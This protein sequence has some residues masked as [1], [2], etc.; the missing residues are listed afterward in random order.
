MAKIDPSGTAKR[1]FRSFRNG[2]S[3]HRERGIDPLGTML[4][5][6]GNG[7]SIYQEL[8]IAGE[9]RNSGDSRE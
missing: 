8:R 3:I 4:R 6:I 1:V 2:L 9:S 5:S 7:T